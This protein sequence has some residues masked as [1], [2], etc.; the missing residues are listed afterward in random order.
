MEIIDNTLWIGEVSTNE[1][2]QQYGSP[3]YVYDEQV[4]RSQYRQ[5]AESFPHVSLHVHYAMKANSNPA[6]LRIL[7]QEGSWI[8]AVS[9][10]EVRLALETGFSPA[11]I[12]FTGNNITQE[13][14]E[15][16][17]EQK[18][19]INIESLT[20][21][22]RLGQLNLGGKVSIRI[23]PGIGAGYHAHCITGGPQSK[24]G[25]Y[26]DQMDQA[27][28]IAKQSGLSINGI[29]SHI[30]TGIFEAEPMLEAMDMTLN[31]ARQIPG[32]QFIDFGGGFAI[33]YKSE[34]QPLNVEDLGKRM[35]ERFSDFCE[36]YGCSLNMK[37]EPGRF[38]VASAGFLIATVN[39]LK[40]T[41]RYRFAGVNSGF[42][43]LVRP[44][45][46]G[47]YH[48]IYNASRMQGEEESVVIVGNICESGDIFSRSNKDQIERLI[49]RLQLGDHIAIADVGAY[50]M[51]MSSQYNMRSR[52]PEVLVNGG[53]SRLIRQ[54]ESYEDLIRN[55]VNE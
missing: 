49:P 11:Q 21:L 13:E 10:F 51:A 45:M 41:P 6:I 48:K 25:I 44:T 47:S 36:N 55:Y 39:T 26:Y 24:F 43:H 9:P 2:V 50:G 3:V 4:I 12:L 18:V 28:N 27:I 14:L 40:T 17:L 8:D 7:L 15:Y 42:N 22:E 5:L 35:S 54:R 31:V 37:I 32:L 33:P 38:L 23:N 16:C 30:G 29:H 52:P 34:Q 46:Y 1:I 53:T 20:W 19:A